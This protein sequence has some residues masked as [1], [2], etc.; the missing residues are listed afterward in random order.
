[1]AVS[2]PTVIIL[3]WPDDESTIDY[4]RSQGMPR[5]L[6]VAPGVDA[7]TNTDCLEDWIRHPAEDADIRVRTACLAAR[8][9]LHSPA[10][11]VKGDGRIS[12]R[13][14]WVALSGIEEAVAQILAQHLGEVVDGASIASAAW[15]GRRSTPNAIRVHVHRI[16]KRIAP[17]GLAV[18][19]VPG[20]GWVM[21]AE[22]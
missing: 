6:L 17:L 12:Y 18:R 1:M 22:S 10:P 13:G 16:R 11:E 20:H 15:G 9:A 4:L 14:K 19:T 3:R 8:S 7:P 21:E 5:L 2:T